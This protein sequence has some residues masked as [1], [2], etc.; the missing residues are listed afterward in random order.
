MDTVCEGVPHEGRRQ[1]AVALLARYPA[2]DDAELAELVR[3]FKKEASALDVGLIASDPELCHSYQRLKDDHLTRLG[4]A[5]LLWMLILF[6]VA[7]AFIGLLI[8]SGL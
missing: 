3:W 8:W 4:A 6:G 7:I 1:S 2:L 5:D